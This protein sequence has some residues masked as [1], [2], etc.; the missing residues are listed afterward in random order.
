MPLPGLYPPFVTS[1]TPSAG[2]TLIIIGPVD[3]TFLDVSAYDVELSAV[4]QYDVVFEDVSD[5]N[6]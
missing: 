3:V 5:I 6:P 2:T 1:L 4:N